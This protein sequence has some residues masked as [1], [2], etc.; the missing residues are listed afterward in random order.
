MFYTFYS[1]RFKD[2]LFA[3]WYFSLL[4]R[5]AGDIIYIQ[6]LSQNENVSELV[7][8]DIKLFGT[9]YQSRTIYWEIPPALAERLTCYYNGADGS[10]IIVPS[11]AYTRYT[12]NWTHIRLTYAGPVPPN[13]LDNKDES[14]DNEENDETSVTGHYLRV[15]SAYWLALKRLTVPKQTLIESGLTRG[16]L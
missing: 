4:L 2:R 1:V 11:R 3:T 9:Y 8:H 14:G 6:R 13:L 7:T 16:A 10:G 12:L 5:K 15:F